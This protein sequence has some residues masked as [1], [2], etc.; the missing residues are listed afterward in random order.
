M[1]KGNILRPMYRTDITSDFMWFDVNIG[2]LDLRLATLIKQTMVDLSKEYET[3]YHFL[4]EVNETKVDYIT[5]YFQIRASLRGCQTMN[6]LKSILSYTVVCQLDEDMIRQQGELVLKAVNLEC[7]MSGEVD[8]Y[9]LQDILLVI[10]SKPKIKMS[11][12]WF[13][14]LNEIKEN[15]KFNVSPPDSYRVTLD[16]KEVID[17]M[18]TFDEYTMIGQEWE[19]V[20]LTLSCGHIKEGLRSVANIKVSLSDSDL[21]L[22]LDSMKENRDLHN[23][24]Y[25]ILKDSNSEAL[26]TVDILSILNSLNIDINILKLA[27]NGVLD[28]REFR[29]YNLAF[30][31]SKDSLLIQS[32]VGAFQFKGRRCELYPK[33]EIVEEID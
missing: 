33:S 8:K 30:S 12:N 19:P 22:F 14:N 15:V 21:A 5:L 24:L 2:N 7:Y 27:M 28:W 13:L 1:L 29:G 6:P 26:K 23:Y 9:L 10:G 16:L 32:S 20:P 4:L 25:L 18:M 17:T 3:I 31:K 11:E